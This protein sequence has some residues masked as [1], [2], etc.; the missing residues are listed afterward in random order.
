MCVCTN[1]EYENPQKVNKKVSS[2]WNSYKVQSVGH[3]QPSV[4]S[5][6]SSLFH[7]SHTCPL[8]A[9]HELQLTTLNLQCIN[10]KADVTNA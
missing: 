1:T 8:P 3:G 9:E 7:S 5:F 2:R 4:T 6:S 10:I